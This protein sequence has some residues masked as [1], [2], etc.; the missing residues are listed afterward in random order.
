M[1][2]M[3]GKPRSLVGVTFVA[4]VFLGGC[5]RVSKV[6]IPPG[7]H[8]EDYAVYNAVINEMYVTN[9]VEMIVIRD[10][11]QWFI[12]ADNDVSKPEVLEGWMGYAEN[13][14]R[15][16][17]R[18]MIRDFILKN[19]P[20]RPLEHCFNLKVK[21][22]LMSKKEH[23][24]IFRG[25]GFDEFYERYPNSQGIMTLSLVSFDAKKARALVFVCNM[26][27]YLGGAEHYV[28]LTKKNGCWGIEDKVLTGLY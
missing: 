11:T 2:M 6:K 7:V 26:S 3:R 13:E 21:Y 1:I 23:D 12:P 22:T 19:K 17:P 4:I 25:G 10:H 18:E 20:S 8:A 16:A 24:K 15:I 5:A 9:S 28:L 27:H 14:I